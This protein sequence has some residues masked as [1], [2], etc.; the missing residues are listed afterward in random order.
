MGDKGRRPTLHL[1]PIIHLKTTVKFPLVYKTAAF[2][3]RKN[4]HSRRLFCL[5]HRDD[6]PA[7]D[8]HNF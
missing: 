2:S 8:R 1:G 6:K 7:I 5:D 3:G 4:C